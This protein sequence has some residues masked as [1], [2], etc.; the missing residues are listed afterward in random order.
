MSMRVAVLGAGLM[1]RWHAR[2]AQRAGGR[3]VAIVDR[4]RAAAERLAREVGGAASYL[5]DGDWLSAERPEVVH[6]CTPPA[7][8]V[9]PA[10]AALES[11][12]SVI[13]EKPLAPTEA[14]AVELSRVAERCGRLLVPVHQFP[15]QAGFRSLVAKLGSLGRMRS[16]EFV[17]FTAGAEGRSAEQRREVLLE[18]FPHA[19]SL[20]RALGFSSAV[21][22]LECERFDEDALEVS[23]RVAGTRLFARVDLRSRPTRNELVVA[24][25][26]GTATVDLFHG[27][28]GV[29]RASLGR[30][31]KLLRPFRTSAATFLRASGNLAGRTLRREPAY[32][33]LVELLR[34]TYDAI[35][36]GGP[37]PIHPDEAIE[38][39]ALT[40]RL[41]RSY[42]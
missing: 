33:G 39:A 15:F 18:I 28:G 19:V 23:A 5:A 30:T 3:V 8:H 24:G 42:R 37:P 29:D 13:V 41:R 36:S 34:A 7:V 26:G 16:V 38:A 12:A 25:D 11:G 10:R 22:L 27:F 14:D 2:Y 32:P 31:S 4:D 9:A 21:S 35:R 1:G 40:E 17:T 6:V 20:F